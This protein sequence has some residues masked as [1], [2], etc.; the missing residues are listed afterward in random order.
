MVEKKS[1]IMLLGVTL[2]DQLTFSSYV[3]NI[4]SKTSCQIGVLLRLRNL[5]PTSAKLHIAK[6]AILPHV[7]YCQ[8]VW[9]FCRSSDARKL[10]NDESKNVH[11][12]LFT[13]CD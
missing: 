8:T 13:D 6:F 10:H 3:S 7:T 1:E 11:Y 5:I 2:D 12:V 4:C 9:H